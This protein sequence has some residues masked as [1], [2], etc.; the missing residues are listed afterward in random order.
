[1]CPALPSVRGASAKRVDHGRGS[2]GRLVV[3]ERA[4]VEKE[5][6]VPGA[7]DN[8]RISQAQ[9]SRQFIG[10]DVTGVDGA[11]GAFEL[12]QRKGAAADL[13]ESADDAGRLKTPPDGGP[14]PAICSDR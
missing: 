7:A 1:M 11:D 5:P 13:R 8:G 9:P 14:G 4:G 10:A 6:A 2:D 12:E 3:G